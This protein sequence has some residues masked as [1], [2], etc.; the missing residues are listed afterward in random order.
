MSDNHDTTLSAAERQC[1]V[2]TRA[3]A[4]TLAVTL[5]LFVPQRSRSVSHAGD[6]SPINCK[7]HSGTPIHR[8]A[9]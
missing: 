6:S 3:A 8:S 2:T 1:P 9:S 4:D 5:M 7:A